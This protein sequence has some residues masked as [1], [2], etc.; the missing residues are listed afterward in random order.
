MKDIKSSNE[1]ILSLCLLVL[2]CS[3]KEWF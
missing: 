3:L 1:L 2:V